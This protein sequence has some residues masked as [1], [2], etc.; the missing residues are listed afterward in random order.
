MEEA[1]EEEEEEDRHMQEGIWLKRRRRA[2]RLWGRCP[3]MAT[4]WVQF[5][6]DVLFQYLSVGFI[7][8]SLIGQILTDRN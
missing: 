1:E 6:V 5:L 2:L 3:R 4:S 8:S 7:R